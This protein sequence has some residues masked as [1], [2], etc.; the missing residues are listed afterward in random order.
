M[1][2][3]HRGRAL[4]DAAVAAIVPGDDIE[5]GHRDDTL[6]WIRGGGPLWRI[7]KPATP[8]KHLVAYSALV[9][10]AAGACLLVAHRNAGLW[11]PPGGHMEEGEH[12][13][14][15]ARREA[16]EELGLD[17]EP[18]AGLVS[19]PFFITATVTGGVDAGHTDVSLWCVLL[20]DASAPVTADP[21]EHTAARWW[22]YEE[23]GR[24]P[25][26]VF[27]P[28]LGRFLAKLRAAA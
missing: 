2:E 6:K 1:S 22:S 25:A 7:A 28:H 15:A 13:V 20:G 16:G 18:V 24:S 17:P 9:D 14:E 21:V 11:L 12:P 4:V 19:N 5:A 8:P 26:D 10:P 23:I 27:D 3:R